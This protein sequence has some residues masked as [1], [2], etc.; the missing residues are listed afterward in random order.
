MKTATITIT[1]D[2]EQIHVRI[3]YD[4]MP[5][6]GKEPSQAAIVANEMVSLFHD[7]QP[8]EAIVSNTIYDAKTGETFTKDYQSTI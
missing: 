8:K 6:V 4:P 7:T 2:N 1:E 5:V 3:G